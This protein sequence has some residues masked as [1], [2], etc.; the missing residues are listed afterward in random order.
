MYGEGLCFGYN[1][2]FGEYYLSIK[3]PSFEETLIFSENIDSFLGVASFVSPFYFKINND[4]YST[5]W[6]GSSYL[7]NEIYLH[8]HNQLACN[9]YGSQYAWELSFIVNGMSEDNNTSFYS[10]RFS[11]IE[12]EA[13]ET[14]FTEIE[15]ST[16]KQTGYHDNFDR[17]DTR[18]WLAPTYAE[19]KW[20]LPIQA[21]TSGTQF[22]DGSE[23]NQN[24]DMRGQWLKIQLRNQNSNSIFVKNVI[25]NYEISN[26]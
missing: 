8:D 5:A 12:I 11:S 25:T 7:S 21:Q 9:F 17:N 26:F 22:F 2:K 20:K 16:L 14:G 6:R 24:S 13:S 15:Y 19:G 18:F 4:F 23:F 1:K 3:Y 10:K